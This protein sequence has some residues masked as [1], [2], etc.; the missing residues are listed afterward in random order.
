MGLIQILQ[1]A[2]WAKVDFSLAGVFKNPSAQRVVA[3]D[4]NRVWAWTRML[5]EQVDQQAEKEEKLHRTISFNGQ[6]S[7]RPDGDAII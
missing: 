2:I 5:A 3:D 4:F 7:L 6:V 1:E